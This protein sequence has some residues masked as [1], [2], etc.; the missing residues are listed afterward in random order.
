MRGYKFVDRVYGPDL[1]MAV[2]EHSLAKGYRHFFYGGAIGTPELLKQKMAARYPGLQV[3]GTCS[4][5]FRALAP[6]EDRIIVNEINAG[7][8]DIIWVGLGTP[9]QEY[10]MAAHL[11][12]VNAPLMIGV[13]AAFDF[14][15]GIKKQAPRWI[16]RSGLEWFFR[17]MTEPGRLWKRYLINNP[18]F[19]IL[20]L[21]QL[22]R[23][24][25]YR[26]ED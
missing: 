16:Q 22:L 2:C 15:A 14:L 21:G 11:G 17:L 6:G 26:L 18:L 10:W 3:A 20:L 12:M 19:I 8:P 4:P 13:G 5:P 7:E 1:M 9:K 25:H 23:I 24:T